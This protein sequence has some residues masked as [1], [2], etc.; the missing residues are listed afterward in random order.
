MN[1]HQMNAKSTGIGLIDVG[2]DSTLTN[3]KQ[4]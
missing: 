1:I 2:S 4:P 3:H